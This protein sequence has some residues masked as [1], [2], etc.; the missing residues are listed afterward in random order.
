M[1]LKNTN[2]ILQ[3]W[4]DGMEELQIISINDKVWNSIEKT[5]PDNDVY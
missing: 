3:A 5:I 4:R 2:G 1:L